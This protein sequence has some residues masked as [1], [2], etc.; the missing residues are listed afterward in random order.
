MPDAFIAPDWR[1]TSL[2]CLKRIIVGIAWMPNRPASACSSSVLTLASRTV[3]S[4]WPAAC[5]NCGAMALHG[6]HHG[7]QKSTTKGMSLLAAC[8]SKL[9]AF[10]ATGCPP[11]SGAP[12]WPHLPPA[13]AAS[14]SRGAR[15]SVLQLGQATKRLSAMA[16]LDDASRLVSRASK[17]SPSA[18]FALCDAEGEVGRERQREQGD[19]EHAGQERNVAAVEEPAGDGG[20]RR[21]HHEIGA[22]EDT[23]AEGPLLR[24]HGRSG[25]PH[26]EAR[27]RHADQAEQQAYWHRPGDMR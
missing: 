13:P 18:H 16:N 3:G 19:G 14:F 20:R 10:R 1:A 2:P 6:P 24:R 9:W 5:S 12:Q 7:A 11:N 27:R 23:H 26:D 8:V 15:F 25:Q 22:E 21:R 4:R 17:A